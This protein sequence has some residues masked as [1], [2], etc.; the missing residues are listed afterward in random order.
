MFFSTLAA[1]KFGP[2]SRGMIADEKVVCIEAVPAEFVR[3]KMFQE[4]SDMGIS[5]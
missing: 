3:K 1:E 4:S 2:P 5:N